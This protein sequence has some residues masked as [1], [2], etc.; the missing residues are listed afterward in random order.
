[1]SLESGSGVVV[2][3][4]QLWVF[5]WALEAVTNLSSGR[6]WRASRRNVVL[7]ATMKRCYG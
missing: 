3:E 2:R 5:L 1:M 6:S 4:R 7:I